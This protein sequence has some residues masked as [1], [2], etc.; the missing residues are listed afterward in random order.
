MVNPVQQNDMLL[1]F[2]FCMPGSP[3]NPDVKRNIKKMEEK[4]ADLLASAHEMLSQNPQH[5]GNIQ[6]YLSQLSLSETES[7]P[8]LDEHL[9]E[10]ARTSTLPQIFTLM[11]RIGAW[12]FLNFHLLECLGKRFGGSNLQALIDG[13]CKEAEDFKAETKIGDF[14]RVWSGR[15]SYGSTPKRTPLIMELESNWEEYTLSDL[16]RHEKWLATEFKI[17]Q[18]AFH[19]SGSNPGSVLLMWLIPTSAIPLIIEGI[20]GKMIDGKVN[21]I[22]PLSCNV[23]YTSLILQYFSTIHNNTITSFYRQQTEAVQ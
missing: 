18:F 14:I 1:N 11:S 7:I 9:S 15:P 13:Y 3:I 4:F 10:I 22:T 5:L 21:S 20:K 8:L 17:E 19:F 12:D 2:T 6:V 16:A 23:R